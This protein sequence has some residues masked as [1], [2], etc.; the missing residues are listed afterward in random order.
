MIN[1]K[2]VCE[3]RLLVRVVVGLKVCLFVSYLVGSIGWS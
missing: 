3:D 2:I 1:L